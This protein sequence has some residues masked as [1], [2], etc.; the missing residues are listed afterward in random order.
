MNTTHFFPEREVERL[1]RL[2]MQKKQKRYTTSK[3]DKFKVEIIQ[4][5]KAGAS[6]QAIV[7]WL[8]ERKIQVHKST[9]SRW[10]YAKV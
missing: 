8:G 7:L 3:L 10:L 4:L 2:I 6:L 5:R 9:V 1:E